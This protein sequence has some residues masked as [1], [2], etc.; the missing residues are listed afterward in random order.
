MTTKVRKQPLLTIIIPSER[1][2]HYVHGEAVAIGDRAPHQSDDVW[3][4]VVGFR[5]VRKRAAAGRGSSFGT[6][7]KALPSLEP[8]SQSRLDGQEETP[9]LLEGSRQERWYPRT[10][11]VP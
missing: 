8:G 6:T 1:C 2:A 5:A 7:S 4:I 9:V 3:V 11:S 10:H